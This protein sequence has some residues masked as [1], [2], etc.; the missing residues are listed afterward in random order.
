VDIVLGL[1][2]SALWYSSKLDDR[3]KKLA[4]IITTLT[5]YAHGPVESGIQGTYA[6]L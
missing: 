1:L 3:N 5:E 6:G 2:R 4:A